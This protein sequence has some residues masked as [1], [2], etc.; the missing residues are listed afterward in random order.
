MAIIMVY[1]T[2]NTEEEIDNFYNS[3]NNAKAQLK[4]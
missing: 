3:M 1:A 2:D 4:S